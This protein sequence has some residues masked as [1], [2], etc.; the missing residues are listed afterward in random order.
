MHCLPPACLPSFLP[1]P[2]FSCDGTWM[3]TCLPPPHRISPLLPQ[4]SCSP[5]VLPL[6][7]PAPHLLPPACLPTCLVPF[8]C[9]LHLIIS[10]WV[11]ATGSDH[12][13]LGLCCLPAT[14][15]AHSYVGHHPHSLMHCHA[16]LP[17]RR[18]GHLDSLLLTAAARLPAAACM[19]P[20]LCLPALPAVSCRARILG[21][22]FTCLHL[23]GSAWESPS[24]F[25]GRCHLPASCL[26]WDRLTVPTTWVCLCH[27]APC[28]PATSRLP[29]CHCRL[30]VCLVL[31][32]TFWV[33][34]GRVLPACHLPCPAPPASLQ[35][36]RLPHTLPACLPA[37]G[38][39]AASLGP[40][41]FYW[42]WTL[43]PPPLPRFTLPYRSLFLALSLTLS[44][45]WV[46]RCPYYACLC[47]HSLP[48]RTLCH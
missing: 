43:L 12:W 33:H 28:H 42:V 31:H 26:L 29:A 37:M 15:S 48:R 2:V 11:T 32:F 3:L 35:R 5:A 13:D 44:G 16:A 41:G 47:L 30:W 4:V 36:P 39:A 40:A 14:R 9:C 20:P 17:A 23:V 22:S 10:H 1:A 27:S 46:T 18:L 7:P 8:T 6:P 25:R 21:S 34:A 38:T 19:P 24:T 45:S